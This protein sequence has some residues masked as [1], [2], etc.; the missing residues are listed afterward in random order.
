MDNKVVESLRNFRLQR[1]LFRDDD[2]DKAK[3][4]FALNKFRQLKN[5]DCGGGLE[6]G[7]DGVGGD[8]IQRRRRHPRDR[9]S[10]RCRLP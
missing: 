3:K 8:D 4:L 5:D 7:I 9:S 1:H 6:A 10:V 2:A